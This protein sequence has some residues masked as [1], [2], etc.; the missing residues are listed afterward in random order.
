M[1]YEGKEY[2]LLVIPICMEYSCIE[3]LLGFIQEVMAL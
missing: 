3:I 2:L 1:I